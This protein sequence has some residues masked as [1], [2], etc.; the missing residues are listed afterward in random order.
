MLV[1]VGFLNNLNKCAKFYRFLKN[2]IESRVCM[3]ECFGKISYTS[4]ELT[5]NLACMAYS[6]FP[7]L[8]YIQARFACLRSAAGGH[9]VS[10]GSTL[11]APGVTMINY[12]GENI[13]K[14]TCPTVIIDIAR[15][16][17]KFVNF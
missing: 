12:K 7:S 15:K 8:L 14:Y 13:P 16:I 2:K 11:R 17:T 1:H 10:A 6:Y 3:S 4:K 9:F 5:K